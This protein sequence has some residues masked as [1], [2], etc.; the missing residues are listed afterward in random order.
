MQSTIASHVR[1]F[2]IC[3]NLVLILTISWVLLRG[4]GEGLLAALVGGL[5]LDVF[6]G[7]PF[8]LATISLFVASY[9]AG[10]GETNVF[11]TARL[12][13]YV[14]IALATLVYNGLFLLL[15]QLMGRVVL[16]GPSLYRILLPAMIVNLLGMPVIYGLCAWVLKRVQPRRAEWQ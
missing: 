2:G 4:A 7:T 15:A 14:A 6:S 12:L 16:W 8:G 5:M 3:P 9:L 11:R 10:L 13:P 1:L